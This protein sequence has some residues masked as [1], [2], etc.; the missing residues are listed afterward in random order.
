[1]YWQS[2]IAG[3]IAGFGFNAFDVQHACLHWYAPLL[4]VFGFA[5][6]GWILHNTQKPLFSAYCFGLTYHAVSL[7]WVGSAFDY[8]HMPYLKPFA[9]SALAF[10]LAMQFP[11]SIWLATFYPK[12]SFTLKW[13]SVF[14]FL[15]YL[16]TLSPLFLPWNPMGFIVGEFC[17]SSI[18]WFGLLGLSWFVLLFSQIL[19][20]KRQWQIVLIIVFSILCIDHYLYQKKPTEFMSI[21]GRIVQPCISQ[22]FKWQKEKIA[23]NAETFRDLSNQPTA[24]KLDFILWPESALPVYS[25][26]DINELAFLVPKGVPVILGHV[27]VSENNGQIFAALSCADQQVGV[28]STYQKRFLVPFG[29]YIPVPFLDRVVAVITEQKM[30]FSPGPKKQIFDFSQIGLPNAHALICYESIFPQA[31]FNYQKWIIEVSNDAWF[32]FSSGPYQHLRWNQIRCLENN[33]PLVRS[34]NHGISAVI[35][36]RGRLV[37]WLGL[38]QYGII[39]CHIPA[40]SG[41]SFYNK[42]NIFG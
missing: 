27:Q 12:G 16:R 41:P 14:A 4:T 23:E 11:L 29:E 36:S 21:Y 15:D 9:S 13:I 32:G 42:L 10:F 6:L 34:T 30:G 39:D 22:N 20:I 35:D 19:Y 2:L 25:F 17:L 5:G 18:R 33:I 8:S 1:M 31:I 37:K 7:F 3:Y 24:K 40:S 28:R 38:G 26:K